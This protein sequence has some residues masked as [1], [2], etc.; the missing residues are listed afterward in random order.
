MYP[1]LIG[2]TKARGLTH[3]DMGKLFGITPQAYSRK[4]ITGHF[5]PKECK[6][7]MRYFDKTFDYLFYDEC[8]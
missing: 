8:D 2:I 4:V 3:K 6:T 5:T 7:L 1:N